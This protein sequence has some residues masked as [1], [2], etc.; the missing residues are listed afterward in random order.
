MPQGLCD[1]PATF[2]RSMDNLL[3]DLKF[4]CLLVFL[5]DIT[6]FQNCFQDHH[7]YLRL[8]FN[9]LRTHG[10]KLE[11]SKC[12]FSIMRC[13][14]LGIECHQGNF[15]FLKKWMI[16]KGLTHAQ[17]PRYTGLPQLS[18]LLPAV[19]PALLWAGWNFYLFKSKQCLLSWEEEQ[20]HAFW[21]PQEALASSSIQVH[22]NFDKSFSCLKM[23]V[24]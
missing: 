7:V 2:Q 6:V 16:L 14:L 20:Y 19:H 23:P 22:P 1:A 4:S 17:S 13:N 18:R 12:S 8:V 3:G 21:V 9:W 24:K 15:P 11:P 10:L 5:D